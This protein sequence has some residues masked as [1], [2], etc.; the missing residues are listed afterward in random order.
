MDI[1]QIEQIAK[2]YKIIKQL[3]KDVIALDKLAQDIHNH[4]G[5]LKLSLTHEGKP[6]KENI[7]D[8]DGS[9]NV[10]GLYH[11]ILFSN[12]GCAI[13]K[14]G[15]ETELNDILSFEMIGFLIREKKRV[16]DTLLKS[17]E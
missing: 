8:E 4:G 14:K 15:F 12:T 3:E 7:L 16:I 9:L 11:N 1:K 2:R 6:K 17:F 10:N 5:G 13:T